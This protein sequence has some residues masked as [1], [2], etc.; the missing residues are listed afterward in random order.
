MRN[1]G[2]R[3]CTSLKLNVWIMFV[4]YSLI[5]PI[6]ASQN[7]DNMQNEV[8]YQGKTSLMQLLSNHIELIAVVVV[9]I[10]TVLIMFACMMAGQG[11]ASNIRDPPTFDPAHASTYPFRRYTRDL[12]YWTVLNHNMNPAQKAAAVAMKLRGSAARLV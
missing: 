7:P 2:S 11:Q 5:V 10:A 1:R 4:M 8:P 6:V 12:M 3:A 9:P